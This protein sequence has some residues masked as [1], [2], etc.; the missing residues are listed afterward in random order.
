MQSATRIAI[1][2][3]YVVLSPAPLASSMRNSFAGR[4]VGLVERGGGVLV[5]VDAAERVLAIVSHAALRDAPL[6][7][8]ATVWVSFK[9]SAV[10]T[11]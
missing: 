2:P 11:W 4:I 8:G 1:D 3:A 7:I 10:Q 6:V 5:T 9:S